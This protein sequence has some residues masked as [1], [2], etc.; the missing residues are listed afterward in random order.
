ME[1]DLKK[2][3]SLIQEVDVLADQIAL[4]GAGMQVVEQNVVRMKACVKM[5]K[6]GV[7]EPLEE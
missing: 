6:I 3:S 2:L 7:V 4:V 5:L 1:V